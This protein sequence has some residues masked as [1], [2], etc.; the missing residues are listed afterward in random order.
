MSKRLSFITIAPALCLGL[1]L[2]SNVYGDAAN[3]EIVAPEISA[4]EPVEIPEATVVEPVSSVKETHVQTPA[5]LPVVI[6]KPFSPFTGKVKGKKVRLRANAD[7]ESRVIK[8]L[9]RNDLIVVCGEKG[10]FYAVEP[11]AGSKAYVFRSFVLDGVVEGNRVNVRLEPSL[12]A[13]I[14]G[15][16]NSGDRIKGVI[17]SLNNKWYEISP[18]AGT[19]FYVAK[20]FITSIGGPEVKAHLDKRRSAA[21]QLLDAATLLSQ[22]EMKK[23]YREMDIDRI[24]HNYQAVIND[25]TD[26]PELC[27]K[28]KEGFNALQEEYTQRKIAYLEEKSEGKIASEEEQTSGKVEMALNPT[29][30]MKLWEPVEEALYLGWATRNEERSIDEFYAEQR[31]NSKTITGI[32]EAYGA[33][34]KRKP[35]DYIVKEKDLPLA[36]VYSTH[37]NLQDYVGK[38]VT[39][40]VAPRVNNNFAFDAFFVLSVE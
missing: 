37:V 31:Q 19:R 25:Y 8:E 13:P 39:L 18:P 27:D 24:K 21:E 33:N 28:A 9:S 7:L 30:R 4:I 32:V 3:S 23:S 40:R 10:D 29:D 15:H 1:C 17:S 2:M 22:V 35:G 36:Y 38:K 12:D 34:V 11:P 20:E 6:E 16:L 5:P 14:I 26:F